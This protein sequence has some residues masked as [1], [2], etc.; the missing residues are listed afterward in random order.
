MLFLL[1]ILCSDFARE[2]R[3]YPFHSP[4]FVFE[5]R[6]TMISGAKAPD[7]DACGLFRAAHSH[8]PAR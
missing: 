4:A 8:N 7:L 1:P 2:H 5:F 6:N 3:S